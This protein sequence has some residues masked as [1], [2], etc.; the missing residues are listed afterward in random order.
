MRHLLLLLAACATPG[1]T[2]VSQLGCVEATALGAVPNDGLD[3]RA[4]LLAFAASGAQC[5]HVAGQLDVDTPL[6]PPG[7]RR[8]YGMVSL[9]SRKI[10]LGDGDSSVINFRGDAGGVSDWHGIEIVGDDVTIERLSFK[11]EQLTNTIEQ[12]HVIWGRGPLSHV[13]IRANTFDHP[14]RATK[15]G[16]DIEIFGYPSQLVTD[17]VVEDNV[18]LRSGRSFLA[19]HS[20]VVGAR[21]VGNDVQSSRGQDFDL[22]GSGGHKN[23]LIA[24]N[25][26][27]GG[28]SGQYAIELAGLSNSTVARNT[29]IGRGI[30]MYDCDHCLID[31][32][33]VIGSAIGSA[34]AVIDVAKNSSWVV[35]TNNRVSRESSE[36][37]G[38]V[39][40]VGPHG[41]GQPA[42]VLAY[43]NTLTQRTSAS[44][45]QA[46]GV[47][48]L[49]LSGGVIT[50]V[51]PV[52]G[53]YRGAQ[54]N[55]TDQTRTDGIVIRDVQFVGPMLAAIAVSGSHAGTGSVTL[56]GNSADGLVQTGLRCETMGGVTGPIT[57][58]QDQLPI[59]ACGGSG[60]VRIVQ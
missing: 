8:P 26:L 17:L 57:R 54:I 18:G 36:D 44:V 56:I 28:G 32:N 6:A 31:D 22:E 7:G 9:G 1:R 27:R 25:R 35:L 48:D 29:L 15:T 3:D 13:V 12:T 52:I 34:A 42:R 11:T 4:A 23:W 24:Q 46:E 41:T 50:Y 10:I 55:A 60:F 47:V 59:S 14:T 49:T 37:P 45:L 33:D 51:G 40:H 43:D 5:L 53:V 16:D 2:L 38:A 39:L 20:G 30:A 58:V 21:V 19:S